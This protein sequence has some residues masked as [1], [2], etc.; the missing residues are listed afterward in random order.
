MSMRSENGAFRKSYKD[1]VS[2][3]SMEAHNGSLLCKFVRQ[4]VYLGCR[5]A[6]LPSIKSGPGSL[7][8]RQA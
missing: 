6:G 5:V 3:S 8:P 1:V 2:D 4:G 7:L